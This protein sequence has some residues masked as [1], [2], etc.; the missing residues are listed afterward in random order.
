MTISLLASG[1]LGFIVFKHLLDHYEI[2]SVLTDKNSADII[3]L[4]KERGLPFFAGNPRK[5]KAIS[6]LV[7]PQ[8]EVLVS[9]NYLFLIENDIISL[10]S[11]LSVNFHG[12]LL[13]KYR[14]R[15]PHVWAII[16]NETETGITAHKIDT[17][18]DTGDILSQIRIPI[19]NIDTG[20]SI[21]AKYQERYPEFV[22]EVLQSIETGNYS[23]S[24]QDEQQATY[25]GKRT[26]EDGRI[27][28]SWQRERVYNWIRAQAKPYPG[29]F[30]YYNRSKLTVHGA[31][32]SSRGYH[33]TVPNGTILEVRS[34]SLIVK[35]SNGCLELTDYEINENPEPGNILV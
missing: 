20:A 1:H 32:F 9:V 7:D 28:W 18:C 22:A 13:P 5:G 34:N 2:K 11:K 15:T 3:S 30:T 21:L 24:P 14:G 6:G 25:F 12:S 16:N 29:A 26:P 17:G 10:A 19:S 35:T 31:L 8:C 33:Y 23:L 27:D 4:C